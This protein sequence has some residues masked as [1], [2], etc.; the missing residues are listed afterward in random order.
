[1]KHFLLLKKRFFET[2]RATKK[3]ND[4]CSIVE[5][6]SIISSLFLLLYVCT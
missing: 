6:N 5:M 2:V 1:M 3:S 4:S